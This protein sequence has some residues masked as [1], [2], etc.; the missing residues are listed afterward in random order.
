M[1]GFESIKDDIYLF[2]TGNAQ[3]AYDVFGCHELSPGRFSFCVW[4]PNASR[5]SVVGDFNGWDIN[6]AVM[7]QS[8]GVWRT[9]LEALS[10]GDNYK[11]AVI[12]CAGNTVLKSDPFAFH[13]ETR[14]GNA[15]KVWSLDGYEWHDSDFIKK[16]ANKKHHSL[17]MSI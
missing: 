3:R 11:Y 8:C 10:V 16:R 14:P 7:E 2:N 15:S 9:E 5:V 4:A 13:S 1:C 6:A 17:P 12:D